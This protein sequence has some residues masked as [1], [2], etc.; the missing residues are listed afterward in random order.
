[1]KVVPVHLLSELSGLKI[2]IMR[3]TIDDVPYAYDAVNIQRNDHY[4][5]L[6]CE[7]GSGKLMVDFE[8]ISLDTGSIYYALPGQIHHRMY[9]QCVAGWYLAID[10]LLVSAEFRTVFE[11]KLGLQTPLLLNPNLFNQ[12]QSILSIINNRIGD[13]G[14]TKFDSHVT[15]TLLQS[16]IGIVAGGYSQQGNFV[17]QESRSNHLTHQFK[18]M[19]AEN[20]RSLKSP[21]S[22]AKR[23]NVTQNYLNETIKKNTGFPVSYWITS[24]ILM[25]AKRLLFHTTVTVK[26]IAYA[27][28][29]NDAAYFS[30][31]FKKHEGVSPLSFR[32]KKQ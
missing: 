17:R 11:G 5:F 6:L 14:N 20:F 31:L 19:L 8:N 30:K 1:M 23:L 22:Y 13:K 4:V 15:N 3:F 27:V 9:D 25:E 10:N 28:G 12:C 18:L 26:E 16:F 21:S 32:N 29:Y 24:E 2:D 7:K